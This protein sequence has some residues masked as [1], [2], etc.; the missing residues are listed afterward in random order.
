MHVCKRQAPLL[1]RYY[2]LDPEMFWNHWR[3]DLRRFHGTQQA[4]G[5]AGN[6]RAVGTL[7]RSQL[8]LRYVISPT[9]PVR[10]ILVY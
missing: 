9:I 3:W 7:D 8:G 1:E 5:T 2:L 10:A 4:H 6:K